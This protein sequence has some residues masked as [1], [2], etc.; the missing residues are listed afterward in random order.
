MFLRNDGKDIKAIAAGDTAA[1]CRVYER[2]RN[3][4]YR[5]ALSII[6]NGQLAED[7]LQDT[8]IKVYENAGSYAG[9]KEK[10]F[11]MRIAHNLS[12]DYIRKAN[13]EVLTDSLPT[14]SETFH[15]SFQDLL[16]LI[17]NQIDRQIVILKI[18][19][20]YKIKEI[21]S[22]LNMT[23]NAVSKRYRRVLSELK[24]TLKEGERL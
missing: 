23:P 17:P 10:A 22:L 8:I 21:A 24:T 12:V 4:I 3:E 14:S 7:I 5:Y 20:G 1:L 9:G 2:Y 13:K 18:D 15:N 6:K 11:I 16:E 19:C